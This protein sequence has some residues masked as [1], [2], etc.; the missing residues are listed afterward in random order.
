MKK[1]IIVL[2]LFTAAALMAQTGTPPS[3]ASPNASAQQPASTQRGMKAG[4]HRIMQRL[5]EHLNLTPDQRQQARAMF[6]DSSDQTKPLRAKLREERA[7][8]ALAIKAGSEKQIDEITNQNAESLAKLQA[9]HAKT[10]AKLY[11]ILTPDQKAK[12]D[13]LYSR[14]THAK[15]AGGKQND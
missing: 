8:L 11:S 6:R 14:H 7:S 3:S 9:I 5:S 15:G 13:M 2:P 10:M 12:F 4:R 1:S